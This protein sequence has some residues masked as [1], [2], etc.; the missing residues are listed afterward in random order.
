M[1]VGVGLVVPGVGAVLACDGRITGGSGQILADDD[2]KWLIGPGYSATC[3]G[4]LGGLWYDLRKTPPKGWTKL[5]RKL[6]DVE[7]PLVHD[8]DYEILCFD[9]ARLWHMDHQGEAI[10]HERVLTI[11]CGGAYARGV[12]DAHKPPA[13][14]AAAE[15]LARA[16]CASACRHHSSCGGHIRVI[17]QQG[18]RLA[19]R[20]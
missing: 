9:G 14:L 1:T 13:T 18:R 10:P 17:V 4:S 3:A 19:Q 11:G 5:R 7:A 12:I 8:R 6:T 20:K 2:E 16:A 15:K